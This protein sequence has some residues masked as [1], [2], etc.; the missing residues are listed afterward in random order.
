M[1]TFKYSVK[2]KKKGQYLWIGLFVVFRLPKIFGVKDFFKNTFGQ[3]DQT[4]QKDAKLAQ[5]HRN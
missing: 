2:K 5:F 1:R 3:R 4:K